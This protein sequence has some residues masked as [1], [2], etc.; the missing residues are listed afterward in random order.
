[1]RGVCTGGDIIYQHISVISYTVSYTS[2]LNSI[3]TPGV[4]YAYFYNHAY[5]LRLEKLLY[6]ELSRSLSGFFKVLLDPGGG[7]FRSETAV[8][9]PF[10]K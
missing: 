10:R 5:R 4:F 8:T 1:M 2:P 7:F 3:S 6:L 9:K